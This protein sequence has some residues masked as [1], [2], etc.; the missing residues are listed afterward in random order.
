MEKEKIVEII[1]FTDPICTWCWGSEPLLRKLETVYG[2]QLKIKFVMGGLVED[3]RD[4]YDSYNG[5][6]GNTQ[7]SNEQI[8][9]H[10]LEASQRHGMPINIE[11][12]KLFSDEYTSSYPQNIAYK[13][14]QMEDEKLANKFLRKIREATE[15]Q[16]RQTNRTE[17]LIE[18]ANEAG[19][20]ISKFIERFSDGSAEEAFK[21][22]LN[23][24]REYSVRGFPSFLVKYGD[25]KL[26]LRGY[27]TFD[28]VKSVIKR[29]TD[30]A[31]KMNQL[32]KTEDSVVEFLQKYERAA[33][34]EIQS[35]FDFSDD[36]L[37]KITENLISKKLVRKLRTGNGFF[38]ELLQNP[39]FC[40]PDT[41]ACNV[42]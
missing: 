27:Q 41:G 38:V 25:K 40:N 39:M 5:I 29:M 42:N 16:T 28:N 15:I 6:G 24:T 14:A 32:N 34:I 37:N 33:L 19:L 4:F 11:G 21:Q 10:S 26:L 12:L 22:D 18:L 23:I 35:T 13:A 20:D 8:A 1:E 2:D 3:I 7:Q 17:V 9:K 36:E 30:D 31:V